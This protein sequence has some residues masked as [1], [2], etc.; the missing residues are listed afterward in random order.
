MVRDFFDSC[1]PGNNFSKILPLSCQFLS[2][3]IRIAE[4]KEV[5]EHHFHTFEPASKAPPQL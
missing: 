2:V 5:D 1:E 4:E 3:A